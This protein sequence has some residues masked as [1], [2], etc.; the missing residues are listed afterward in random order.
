MPK[1]QARAS[2]Q[3]GRTTA[4]P[5]PL[6]LFG[7]GN[8]VS[9][10]LIRKELGRLRQLR[11]SELEHAGKLRQSNAK[12]LSELQGSSLPDDN[13]PKRAKAIAALLASHEKLAGQKLAAPVVKGG[14][15]GVLAGEISATL[16]PPFDFDV[17]IPTEL[18]GPPADIA[19]TASKAS[20][21]M[22]VSAVSSSDHGFGGGSMFTTVGVYFHPPTAGT[23]R[24]SAKPKFSFQWWTNSLGTSLV[25]SFGE[26]GLTIF[27]VDVASQSTGAVGTIVSGAH[28]TIFTWDKTQS[29]QIDLDFESDVEGSA[30]TSLAVNHTLVYL[31]FV[32]AEAHVEG[33]GW[34]GS[35]AGS[36][37]SVTVPSI[38][39][40]Y[41]VTQVV[42]A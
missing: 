39:Y 15:G 38:S 11:A 30:T 16:V 34:P 25:R 41:R 35:L 24:V 19:A 32:E 37:L 27:G 4:G 1:K 7:G 8:S 5:D 40:D 36:K 23:L 28:E 31:L 3:S 6:H 18:A 22:S 29:G 14:L 9:E 20:G 13:D 2:K 21:Q 26:V 12:H 10:N 17:V 33:I 42:S